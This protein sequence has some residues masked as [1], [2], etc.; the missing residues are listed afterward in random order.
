M[1]KQELLKLFSENENKLLYS[2]FT[3]IILA[4]ENITKFIKK[5]AITPLNELE[6]K[7]LSKSITSERFE[8]FQE[9][10]QNIFED[11]T[12]LF[13]KYKELNKKDIFFRNELNRYYIFLIALKDFI[14]KFNNFE[15]TYK[16]KRNL[17]K[18]DDIK[19]KNIKKVINRKGEKEDYSPNPIIEMIEK[20]CHKV[21]NVNSK[22]I[23]EKTQIKFKEEI[24]T[25]DIQQ[26]ITDTAIDMISIDTPEYQ[27]VAGNLTLEDLNKRVYKNNSIIDFKTLVYRNV[28][29]GKYNKKLIE[30]YDEDELDKLASYIKYNRN[31]L[32][33]YAGIRQCIDKYLIKEKDGKKIIDIFET[34]QEMFMAIS[35]FGFMHY[36]KDIYEEEIPYV[37]INSNVYKEKVV[38]PDGKRLFYVKKF[39]DSLSQFGVNLPTPIMANLRSNKEQ[40]AS[41]TVIDI[42]DSMTSIASADFMTK[43]YTS[44]SSGIGLNNRIRALG[45]TIDNGRVI[46]TGGTPFLKAFEASVKSCSQGSR[47][48]SATVHVPFFSYEIEDV[49]CL[50]NPNSIEEKRIRNMDYSVLFNKLF[51]ERLQK[52]QN[53]TLFSY[54]DVEDMYEAFCS[55][56]YKKFEKLYK[57]YEKKD[58]KKKVIKARE[59]FNLYLREVGD[60]GRIYEVH[61]DLVNIQTPFKVNIY[62]SN[63]CVDGNT[64]ISI[65]SDKNITPI[66]INIKDLENNIK[67]NI[68]V[69]SKNFNK[70]IKEYS[71]ILA[72]SETSKKAKVLKIKDL[73]N[74]KEL[75]CTPD[76]KVFTKN[77]GWVMAKDLVEND[78]LEIKNEL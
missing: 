6:I 48:G 44:Y 49:I 73:E 64:E 23:F 29:K 45:D 52:N 69:L 46:H 5:I 50:K 72:F 35:A 51:F 30:N 65:I 7:E 4:S 32:F 75:I 39:Y 22:E 10:F 55:S 77:R 1:K 31:R 33:T 24:T 21:P 18:L 63:L 71:K 26:A 11:I 61:I 12:E 20:A 42:G 67:D 54:K 13:D 76:H 70:N 3:N 62:S 78:I 60:T 58:I 27:F 43:M 40:Y 57:E 74:N 25:E 59:L 36:P 14:E 56:D 37:D 34:P 66:T 2:E 41:C 38:Y 53:I 28:E 9:D 16:D 17:I 8:V 19:I 68:K 15:K 47:G